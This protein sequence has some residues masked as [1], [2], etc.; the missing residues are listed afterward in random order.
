MRLSHL[1]MEIAA[2]GRSEPAWAP[3][4]A[5][6]GLLADGH[7]TASA[8]TGGFHLAFG[9]GA[10][11][12]FAAFT[13]PVTVLRQQGAAARPES[14]AGSDQAAAETASPPRH[15]GRTGSRTE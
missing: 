11:V 3:E 13:L 10:A 14:T 15:D 4:P 8:M 9:T 12:I 5:G 2:R 6:E 1:G 7:S